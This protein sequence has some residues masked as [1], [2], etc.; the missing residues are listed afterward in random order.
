MV[1]RPTLGFGGGPH[2]SPKPPRKTKPPMIRRAQR[3]L[4]N[5]R[6][7]RANKLMNRAVGLPAKPNR[8]IIGG[9]S[10]QI[11]KGLHPTGKPIGSA[12]SK[13]FR[14]LARKAGGIANRRNNPAGGGITRRIP[15]RLHPN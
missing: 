5:G 11:P 3:A 6:P 10:K 14:K 12:Q 4:S 15:K 2:G 13:P 8:G 1:S 9:I 7:N